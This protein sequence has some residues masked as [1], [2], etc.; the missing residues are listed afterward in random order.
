MY[1]FSE[2]ET[3]I[4]T[5]IYLVIL[6]LQVSWKIWSKL[7]IIF[8][9]ESKFCLCNP[10]YSLKNNQLLEILCTRWLSAFSHRAT[11]CLIVSCRPPFCM[12]SAMI[13]QKIFRIYDWI[14]DFMI[15]G[16]LSI[17]FYGPKPGD[18]ALQR[19]T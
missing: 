1:T 3:G 15:P 9:H 4:W 6:F 19:P 11:W 18:I 16:N 17:S 14:N 5:G 8:R 2:M 13:P 12:V 10:L 7:N